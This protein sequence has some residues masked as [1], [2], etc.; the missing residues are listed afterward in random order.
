MAYDT[1]RHHPPPPVQS[2][3]AGT[4]GFVLSLVSIATCFVISP[5]SLLV[6]FIGLFRRPRGLATAGTAISMVGCVVLVAG[7]GVI[8]FAVSSA[9]KIRNERFQRQRVMRTEN[10]AMQA[11]QDIEAFVRENN[12]K[13]PDGIEGN[14]IVLVHVDAWHRGLRYDLHEEANTYEIRSAG[15]DGEFDTDDDVVVAGSETE[16]NAVVAEPAEFH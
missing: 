11:G 9:G 13:L 10:A 2:N 8:F 16:K 4:L 6:S 1:F 7:M 3:P 15:P 5:V 14:K 12:G